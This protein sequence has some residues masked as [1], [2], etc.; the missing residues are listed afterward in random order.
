MSTYSTKRKRSTNN[1]PRKLRHIPSIP[2]KWK[3][4]LCKLLVKGFW[5]FPRRTKSYEYSCIYHLHIIHISIL[6]IS[7]SCIPWKK[8]DCKFWAK[9]QAI[10]EYKSFRSIKSE[11]S[12]P[13]WLPKRSSWCCGHR[14]S[15]QLPSVENGNFGV[16]TTAV[17][18]F[19]I[20]LQNLIAAGST[21]AIGPWKKNN[22]RTK[23][24]GRLKI[25]YSK[26]FLR[27]SKKEW[28]ESPF[29]GGLMYRK[30]VAPSLKGEKSS[31]RT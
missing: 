14:M 1:Y 7:I 10:L 9:S 28:D 15:W 8:A 20:N 4:F 24:C 22:P 3:E 5:N 30:I 17:M 13:W 16:L 6:Y 11:T 29:G 25:F 18:S 27:S 21:Q 12:H 26:R 23:K 2:Q 19:Q 31:P